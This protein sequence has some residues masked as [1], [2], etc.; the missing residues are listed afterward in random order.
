MVLPLPCLAPSPAMYKL[1]CVSLLPLPSCPRYASSVTPV[2]LPSS[3][4]LSS[5]P[6]TVTAA[7]ISSP[8]PRPP[9]ASQLSRGSPALTPSSVSY[10]VCVSYTELHVVR[11]LSD[12]TKA[13]YLEEGE[14]RPGQRSEGNQVQAEITTTFFV[15]IGIFFPS[16]TGT[17][18]HPPPR[19]V[20]MSLSCRYHGWLQQ[21]WRSERCSEVHSHRDTG[22]HPHHISHMYPPPPTLSQHHCCGYVSFGGSVVYM[23]LYSWLYHIQW[24][25]NQLYHIQ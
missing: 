12:N 10:C 17:S 20:T 7:S 23:L 11:H 24:F 6:P 9:R 1:L 4:E 2:S 14:V 16:V 5:C 18:P 3:T 8:G 22:R 13:G 21:V 15:L 25:Y 19:V